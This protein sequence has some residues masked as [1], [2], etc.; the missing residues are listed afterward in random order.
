MVEFYFLG[1]F[2]YLAKGA[3]FIQFAGYYTKY[4]GLWPLTIEN[5]M[6]TYLL[7]RWWRNDWIFVGSAAFTY[8]AGCLGESSENIERNKNT[9]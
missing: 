4:T 2:I 9:I 5:P 7:E 6:L 1:G 3:N 8:L